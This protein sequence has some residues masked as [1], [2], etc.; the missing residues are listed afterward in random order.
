MSAL[1]ALHREIV[2]RRNIIVLQT[3]MQSQHA[4]VLEKQEAELTLMRLQVK[5]MKEA[6]ITAHDQ[7]IR[8]EEREDIHL[9]ELNYFIVR[10]VAD[11]RRADNMK[12]LLDDYY[13]LIDDCIAVGQETKENAHGQKAQATSRWT[14]E[15]Q[16]E[17]CQ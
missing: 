7:L 17:K 10:A 14:T 9:A 4:S 13:G 6:A 15:E 2:G 11:Q 12:E 3:M 1:I 8:Y 16:S 5:T